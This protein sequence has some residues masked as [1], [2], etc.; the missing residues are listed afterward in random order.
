MTRRVLQTL[1]PITAYLHVMLNG[2]VSLAQKEELAVHD[3]E[4]TIASLAKDHR[5]V[6]VR[7]AWPEEYQIRAR[8]GDLSDLRSNTQVFLQILDPR[9]HC[10]AEHRFGPPIVEEIDPI[11]CDRSFP[12]PWS[13]ANEGHMRLRFRLVDKDPSGKVSRVVSEPREFTLFTKIVERVEMAINAVVDETFDSACEKTAIIS[14]TKAG[15]GPV[16]RVDLPDQHLR[17]DTAYGFRIVLVQ[18]KRVLGTSRAWCDDSARNPN[19]RANLFIPIDINW[20]DA[21]YSGPITAIVV[22]DIEYALRD[23]DKKKHWTG[24]FV[25]PVKVDA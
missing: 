25:V 7:N 8:L 16:M 23:H 19:I 15:V 17:D 1:I 3:I 4:A 10:L 2:P 12:I 21:L 24:G 11:W 13:A 20:R 5:L 18:G 9:D 22:D 14:I 6:L